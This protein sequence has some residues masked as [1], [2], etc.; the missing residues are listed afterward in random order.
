MKLFSFEIINDSKLFQIFEKKKMILNLVK[1]DEI[2]NRRNCNILVYISI[3]KIVIQY[4]YCGKNLIL[5]QNIILL[6]KS[7]LKK[8][9]NKNST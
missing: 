4:F 6:K 9:S 7:Y 5:N 1:T 8:Y 2:T 3:K